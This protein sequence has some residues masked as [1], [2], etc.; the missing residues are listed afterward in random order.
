[1]L[2]HLLPWTACSS[3]WQFGKLQS[4][5]H[6]IHMLTYT[7]RH[8]YT[9]VHGRARVSMQF[10]APHKIVAL[11][12]FSG[13]AGVGTLLTLWFSKGCMGRSFPSWNYF[14]SPSNFHGVKL[15]ETLEAGGTPCQNFCLCFLNFPFTIREGGI[16]KERAE[17]ANQ[18]VSWDG[19]P[20]LVLKWMMLNLLV[21][22]KEP[23]LEVFYTA[24]AS[25]WFAWVSTSRFSQYRMCPA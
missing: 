14:T 21:N 6:G 22:L 7:Q 20:S 19:F 5:S 12:P 10:F 18:P 1:M 2:I 23:H 25:W 16:R 13:Q 8:V 15:R 3:A 4:H 24:S 17:A 9:L 11:L